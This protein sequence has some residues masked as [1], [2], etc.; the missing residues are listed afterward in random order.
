MAPDTVMVPAGS[1]LV[2]DV[3]RDLPSTSRD[4]TTA[5]VTLPG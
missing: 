5:V 3:E 4:L 2:I 1:D